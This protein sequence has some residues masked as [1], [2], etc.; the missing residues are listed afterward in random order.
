MHNR[1]TYTGQQYDR[2]TNQYYLRERYYN[3]VIGRFTQEDVYRGD[4]L[5]LYAYCNNNPIEYCDSSGYAKKI[6]KDGG[7]KE[8][9]HG[10]DKDSSK[11]YYQVTSEEVANELINSDNSQ[12]KGKEFQQIFVCTEQ[13]TYKQAQNSGARSL[14]TVIEFKTS[15]SFSTLDTTMDDDTLWKIARMSDRPSPISISNVK[16]V[17]FKAGKKRWWR[18]W[19]K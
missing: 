19:K 8:N 12:L 5:N 18:F 7:P 14:E 2:V 6:C 10:N 15:A 1:I 13:P 3:P 16:K 9:N 4:G 11:T 17:G